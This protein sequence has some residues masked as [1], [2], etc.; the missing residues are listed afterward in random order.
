MSAP[1]SSLA[2]DAG[3]SALRRRLHW[4]A[5][6]LALATLACGLWI[7][8]LRPQEPAALAAAQWRFSLH[9]TLGAALWLLTLAR[10]AAMA[11]GGF[12]PAG[13]KGWEVFAA[14]AVQALML[15]ALI[16][17][18]VLGLIQHLLIAGAAP[19]WLAPVEPLQEW[20]QRQTGLPANDPQ[21]AGAMAANLGAAH[22]LL[23]WAMLAA[24]ALHLAGAARHALIKGDGVL[25]RMLGRP[26]PAFLPLST[27]GK[28]ARRRGMAAGLALACVAAVM[29]LLRFAPA[30]L[31]T[32][33]ALAPAISAAGVQSGVIPRWSADSQQS[34]LLIEAVQGG[35]P[36]NARFTRFEADILLDPDRPETGRIEARI[37]AKSFVSG[38]AERDAAATGPDWLDAAR[39]PL[40]RWTSSHIRPL[41]AGRYRA[42]GLL[43]I[44]GNSA[45]VDLDFTLRIDGATA[46]ANGEARFA[47][48]ALKLG[49]GETGGADMAGPDIAV[50]VTIR[51]LRR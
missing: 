22:R 15:A 7:V 44:G 39:H 36:F 40:A 1:L 11:R 3:L 9:K 6:V 51:A 2:P 42:S 17:L 47:R 20:F 18:P 33:S 49:R 30:D 32:A 45:P 48:A 26:S 24:L 13:G 43:T 29:P 46:V 4:L 37:D 35:A 10:L 21:R 14:A 16:L 41:E 38:L 19:V 12:S 34:L 28:R 27:S 50:R 25:V 8:W 23:A 31:K 5:A